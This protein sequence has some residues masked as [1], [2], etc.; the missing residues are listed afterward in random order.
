MKLSRFRDSKLFFWTIEILAVVAVIFILL[1][2]KYIFSPI[3]IIISTLFMPILVA[4]FLFYLFNPLVLFLEKRKVPRILS[5]IIIFITFIGL[6]VLAVMQLG[7]TLAEQVTE[8][9]KAIPGYWQ[10][11]EKWLQGISK[12]SSLQGVDLKA[13]LEK[14]NISLPKIMSVVVD[15]VASSFGAIV[16]FVSGFVM[17]LVTVPFIVFYMFK[18]GHK[19]IES[20][21]KF[22]PAAIRAEAKQIIKE[23]NK[24][25]ST[26]I[27]SQAID[28]LVVGLF[29]FIG[30]LIIGQPYALLFGLIAG[31][32]NIIPYLGPFIGAAPA[33]IVALF[34][35]PLQALLVIVVVTIVQQLDS[36]LLSPYIMGK[37]LSIHPLT[38]IIILIVAG[39]LAGIFGMILGVP[40]YA[41]VKTI[42]VNV[43]RLIKLRRGE[44]ALENNPPDPPAP[45]A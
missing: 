45:K 3:G 9:A 10:D 20:S 42:I 2:M 7:P 14:L 41:V 19:F 23:M 22:F 8:L 32:T 13:E 26:Y 44:L 30:Y 17:I 1:Q 37:S 4:G 39:N 35:S 34:T 11:F 25:I 36:N 21:G 24:T 27:S 33:V 16:S 28:C 29:T 12:N 6:I 5:V 31:A 43:N 18:D 38:I 15:G 40:V